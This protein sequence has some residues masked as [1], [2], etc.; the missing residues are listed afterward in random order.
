MQPGLAEKYELFGCM[1]CGKCTA[2]CPVSLRGPLNIRRL[3]REVMIDRNLKAAERQELWDCTT[4][5]ACSLRCPR[6]LEPHEL[7]IGIRSTLIEEGRIPTTAR[8]ALEGVFKHGNPW[9]RIRSKR[10]EWAADL[11]IKDLSQGDKA[12]ML[13]FACCA[14]SYDPR[15]Q[16][17]AKALTESL[18][19]AGVDF[20]I[21][22]NEETCCGSEVRRMGE[23]GLFEMLVEDNLKLFHERGITKVVT[24]SPHCYD[25][26]KN[27][28]QD[29][30][31]EFVHYTQLVADLIADGKLTFSR[32]LDKVVTYHDPCYLGKQNG[33]YDEPR[34]ILKSIPGIKFIEFDR[35]RERSLCCEGGGGRMWVEG[36][37]SGERLS[38]VRI[39]DAVDMGVDIVATACPFCLLTLEDAVKTAGFDGKIEIKDI[40]ELVAQTI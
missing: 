7:I 16:E 27:K 11:G 4:C 8:D 12:D 32:E 21:L 19:K 25:A 18:A 38:A 29:S 2:G 39:K 5:L 28:Y 36:T 17:V 9:G 1:Q 3:V 20:G 10:S 35:S 40:M 14:A 23:E 13:Y 26:F 31:I 6:G 33:I 37:D 34:Y 30:E 22:G 15:V 24:T